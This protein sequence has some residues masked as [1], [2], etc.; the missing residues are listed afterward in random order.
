MS[1]RRAQWPPARSAWDP[2]VLTMDTDDVT[3]SS[4]DESAPTAYLPWG[5]VLLITM[6]V[7]GVL[8]R[9]DEESVPIT[10]PL[11]DSS[12]TT[13]DPAPVP[14]SVPT[15][16]TTLR[17]GLH[18]WVMS[19]AARL[20]DLAGLGDGWDGMDG[21]APSEVAVTSAREVLVRLGDT[22]PA[23]V[24]APF[25]CPVSGGGLQI[26]WTAG[27]RHL[28]VE[29]LSDGQIA[30]LT[31]DTLRAGVSMLSGDLEPHQVPELRRMLR[32]LVSA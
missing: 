7:D 28:E 13:L 21:P 14:A 29:F 16:T 22:V 5:P 11:A 17:E 6:D 26:E 4:Y 31:E 24:P 15:E 27:H 12:A 32:W 20:N 1:Y 9:W 10:P 25:V 2:V 8:R 18:D 23:A 3:R 19:A 30:Y